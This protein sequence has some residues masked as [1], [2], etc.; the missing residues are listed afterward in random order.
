MAKNK[1]MAQQLINQGAVLTTTD[2][3]GKSALNYAN[4]LGLTLVLKSSQDKQTN[5][6]QAEAT[7]SHKI[8]TLKLQAT[9]KKSPYFAW[10][11]LN[12]AVAQ[13]QPLLINELL[14]LKHSAWQENPQKDNAISIAINQEQMLQN[15][16]FKEL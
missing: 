2:L 1:S 11:I 13:K 10:P 12:I 6:K 15:I 14:R 7:L 4:A 3:K 16:E 8:Q 9:N 5:R